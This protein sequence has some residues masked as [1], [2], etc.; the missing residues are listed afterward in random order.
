MG[1]EKPKVAVLAAAEEVNPKLQESTDAYELKKMYENGEFSPCILEGPISIDLA[2]DPESA[3]IKK[4]PSPVGG[5]ADLLICPD[6]VSGNMMGK[7][8]LL[9][10]RT[11]ELS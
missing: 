9:T 11:R 2:L 5:D 3:K 7:G 10:G 4:Y 6:L 8:M 1:I